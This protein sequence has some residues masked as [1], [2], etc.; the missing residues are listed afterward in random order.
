MVCDF[1]AVYHL[2]WWEQVWGG[3]PDRTDLLL[4]GLKTRPDSLL[5]AALMRDLPPQPDTGTPTNPSLDWYGLTQ[6]TRL[7]ALIYNLMGA[8]YGS[9]A[10]RPHIDPPTQSIDP[11]A[12]FWAHLHHTA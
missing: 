11:A 2:D 9:S 1:Q 10:G 3:D 5:R 7:L 4:T 12:Q 6:E 8:Q